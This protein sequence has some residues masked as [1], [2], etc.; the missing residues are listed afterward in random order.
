MTSS[1]KMKEIAR[2]R[3]V[4]LDA[5]LGT[6]EMDKETFMS[7]PCIS[8]NPLKERIAFCFG[9]NDTQ[10][11]LDFTTFLEGVSAFN[12]LGKMNQKVS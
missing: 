12:S 1:F 11:T 3:K 7:L 8:V 6:E 2:I 4:Y 9:Y 10:L 5:T